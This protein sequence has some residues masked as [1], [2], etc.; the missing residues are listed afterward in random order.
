VGDDEQDAGAGRIGWTSP[1]AKAVRGAEVGDVRTVPL[2]GGSKT[3]E[4]I[5]ISYD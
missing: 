2:P 4:V 5:E 1:M 3:W